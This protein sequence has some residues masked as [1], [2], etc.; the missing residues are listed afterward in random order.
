MAS[1]S[2]AA[3]ARRPARLPGAPLLRSRKALVSR[4]REL[5]PGIAAIV[6]FAVAFTS[7][8]YRLLETRA[9]LDLVPSPAWLSIPVRMPLGRSATLALGLGLLLYVAGLFAPLKHRD[10]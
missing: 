4:A 6:G 5:A 10:E 9:S 1:V 3:E 7:W 2:R 8:T